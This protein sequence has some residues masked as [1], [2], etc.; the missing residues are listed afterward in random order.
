MYTRILIHLFQAR[1][2]SMYMYMPLFPSYDHFTLGKPLDL[3]ALRYLMSS[4]RDGWDLVVNHN[5]GYQQ[6]LISKFYQ[7]LVDQQLVEQQLV[8]L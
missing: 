2:L 3:A 5:L 1:I 6:Q 7:Q 8:D 4:P